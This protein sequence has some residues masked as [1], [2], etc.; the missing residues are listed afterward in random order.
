[1]RLPSVDWRVAV[2]AIIGI[3][4]IEVAALCNGIN[5]VGLAAA[6][7]GICAVGGAIGVD[8]RRKKGD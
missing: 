1:M 5:G 3:T 2:A 4:V 7:G 6:V 8:L